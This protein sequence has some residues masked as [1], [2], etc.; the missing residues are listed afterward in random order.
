[1]R[2]L[3]LLSV[4]AALLVPAG[5]A[6]ASTRCPTPSSW[7]RS[8]LGSVFAV[9]AD[10]VRCKRAQNVASGWFFVQSHGDRAQT[11]YDRKGRRWSCRITL[12][13]TGT[14]P[15]YNPYTHVRCTRHEAVV[16]FK[17]RS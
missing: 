2:K 5:S 4:A 16:R 6:H 10:G 3:L 12:Q 1:M 8:D 9:R 7:L 13:A 11:I 17:L 15:G 14:D